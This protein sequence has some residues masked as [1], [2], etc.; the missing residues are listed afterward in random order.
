MTSNARPQSEPP[1]S[2]GSGRRPI[3]SS[4]TAPD[5]PETGIPSGELKCR[6][7]SGHDFRGAAN[8]QATLAGRDLSGAR[9]V[10]CN[11]EGLD[12]TG[13]NFDGADLTNASLKDADLTRASLRGARLEGSGIENAHL[14]GA[15]LTGASTGE[16]QAKL[17]K[18][19]ELAKSLA[20]DLRAIFIASCGLLTYI[21]ASVLGASDAL[22][23]TNMTTMSLPLVDAEVSV[24][25]FFLLASILVLAL[26]SY[27]LA[28]VSHFARV[29]SR[30]PG[31]LP[32][33]PPLREQV[34]TWVL[35]CVGIFRRPELPIRGEAALR[36][37]TLLELVGT[38]IPGWIVRWLGPAVLWYLMLRFFFAVQPRVDAWETNL[39]FAL[40]AVCFLGTWATSYGL[41]RYSELVEGTKPPTNVTRSATSAVLLVLLACSGRFITH[42]MGLDSAAGE[43]LSGAQFAGANLAGWNLA[44]ARLDNATLA[45][46]NLDRARAQEAVLTDADLRRA[47]LNDASFTGAQL[48]GANLALS[49]GNG[50]N[51]G[52]VVMANSDLRRAAWVS[53]I[54]QN[55]D[56]RG[57]KLTHFS[58]VG[59]LAADANFS[60]AQLE[61]ANFSYAMLNGARF[62]GEEMMLPRANFSYAD[63]SSSQFGA[64]QLHQATLDGA[65]L[66][67]ASFN[68]SRLSSVSMK[69]AVLQNA[70]LSLKEAWRIVLNEAFISEVTLRYPGNERL[71]LAE[72]RWERAHLFKVNLT[73]ANLYKAAFDG[74]LLDQVNLSKADLTGATF[75]GATFKDVILTGATLNGVTLTEAQKKEARGLP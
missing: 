14:P 71:N 70:T 3:A 63:L 29:A 35:S 59:A 26:G 25:A 47:S 72:S 20:E 27:T 68:G 50:P 7:W 5:V 33:G 31:K 10:G 44:T 34:D 69:K 45:A 42:S 75:E 38:Q 16:A 55:A 40:I 22:V 36:L 49:V 43:K 1:E 6:E 12:L 57:A 15:D 46:A 54:L 73:N 56:L 67:S 58:G 39:G 11:F 60:G 23:L 48:T 2:K 52:S 28:R 24:H 13:A 19:L 37:S 66:R 74:A 4:S 62:L 51:F 9:L 8:S 32:D 64:A 61:N 53:P 18:R 65:V 41:R 30:L 17:E 21:G